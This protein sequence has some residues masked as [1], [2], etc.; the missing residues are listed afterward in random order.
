MTGFSLTTSPSSGYVL[1]SDAAGKGTWAAASGGTSQ[2]TGAAPGNIYYNQGNVGIG[3][4]NPIAALEVTHASGLAYLAISSG[5]AGV[6][7]DKFMIIN[8]GNVGIASYNPG[9]KLDISGGNARI[10][11]TNAFYFGDEN[12]NFAV[13]DAA[14]GVGIS[15][16]SNNSKRLETLYGSGLGI[17]VT[18]NMGIGTI[19]P[20]AK[21]AIIKTSTIPI[22]QLSS[23]ASGQGDYVIVTNSG[24]MGIGST[25]PGT[26]LDAQG[27]IRALGFTSGGSNGIT[28]TPCGGTAVTS[29][30]IRNGIVTACSGT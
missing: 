27:T 11:G 29:I 5:S 14:T 17:N 16:Y 18:G 2:W 10:Q 9:Q 15:M 1:T 19:N 22:M 13:T 24:N 12:K 23:T 30:T 8:G 26:L 21:L 28:A 7:G 20:Q 6:N 3:S 4:S 25:A